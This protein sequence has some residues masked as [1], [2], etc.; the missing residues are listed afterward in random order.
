M[1]AV[2]KADIH[3][4]LDMRSL[5]F[6]EQMGNHADVKCE[7]VDLKAMPARLIARLLRPEFKIAKN[8]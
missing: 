7:C 2:Q 3:L 5:C 6:M 4:V 8:R 1:M